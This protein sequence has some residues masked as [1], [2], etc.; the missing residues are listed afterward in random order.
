[1]KENVTLS[2]STVKS[3][4]AGGGLGVLWRHINLYV[5]CIFMKCI[6]MQSLNLLILKLILKETQGHDGFPLALLFLQS[7]TLNAYDTCFY[8]ENKRLKA[9]NLHKSMVTNKY[10]SC[11]QRNL[12]IIEYLR[13]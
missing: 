4:S 8:W 12:N 10:L 9:H 5:R 1:M 13:Y 6:R 2:N 3:N 11:K 7:Y